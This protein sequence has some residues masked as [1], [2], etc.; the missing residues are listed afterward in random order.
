MK[1]S[2]IGQAVRVVSGLVVVV[3]MAAVVYWVIN[4]SN[5]RMG[6]RQTSEKTSQ[7]TD[8]DASLAVTINYT[9]AGFPSETF[10]V[11]AGGTV[12]VKNNSDHDLEFSSGSHPTHTDEPELNMDVLRPGESGSFKVTKVGTWS[13]HNHLKE[14]DAGSLMVM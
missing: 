5:N 11:K 7:R 4:S 3:G 9:N 12:T 6:A 10:M 2:R 1:S 14:H 13:F 8:H